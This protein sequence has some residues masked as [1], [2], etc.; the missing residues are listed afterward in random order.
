MRMALQWH[1]IVMRSCCEAAIV[2][3]GRWMSIR[4]DVDVLWLLTRNA[5]ETGSVTEVE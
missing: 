5:N 3:A 2:I 4:G 1:V